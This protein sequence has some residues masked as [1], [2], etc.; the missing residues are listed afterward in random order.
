[1]LHLSVGTNDLKYL[2]SFRG[3]PGDVRTLVRPI[4]ELISICRKYFGRSVRILFHSVLPMKCIHSFT[5]TNFESFNRLLRDICNR[6]DC[7]YIDWFHRFLDSRGTEIDLNLYH[8]N[9]HLN[10]AGTNVLNNLLSDFQRNHFLNF[11]NFYNARHF[12]RF[13]SRW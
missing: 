2:R 8:D 13:R 5:A 3:G 11:P 7:Y 12:N 4:E 1:M 10:R 9:L 6:Q